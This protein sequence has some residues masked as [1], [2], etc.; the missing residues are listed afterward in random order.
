MAIKEWWRR[1]TICGPEDK[2]YRPSTRRGTKGIF[3]VEDNI[4]GARKAL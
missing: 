4:E 2:P 1:A 3:A